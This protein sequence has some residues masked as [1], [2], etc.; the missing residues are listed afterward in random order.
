MTIWDASGKV[1]KQS[2]SDAGITRQTRGGYA[3]VMARG[4]LWRVYT[5]GG[6]LPVVQVAQRETVRKEIAESAG[7]SAALPVLSVIP[8]G[9]LVIGWA[10]SRSLKGLDALSRNIAARDANASEPIAMAQ[11]P[12]EVAP[13]VRSM[14]DLVGAPASRDRDTE[15]VSGRCSS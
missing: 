15:A 2:K 9:W 3:D 10:I 8:L 11:V 7:I 13:L 4:E 14:N 6:A 1:L 5:T 12:V